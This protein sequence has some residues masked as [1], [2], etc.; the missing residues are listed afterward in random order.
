MNLTVLEELRKRYYYVSHNFG[1]P[2]D[3]TELMDFVDDPLTTNERVHRLLSHPGSIAVISPW[4]L[5]LNLVDPLKNDLVFSEPIT[6]YSSEGRFLYRVKKH[7]GI[8]GN[9]TLDKTLTLQS[10]SG[11]IYYL[12]YKTLSSYRTLL[13]VV[14]NLALEPSLPTNDRSYLEAPEPAMTEP[15]DYHLILN[16]TSVVGPTN[17]SINLHFLPGEPTL[18]PT[19]EEVIESPSST[20]EPFI[21]NTSDAIAMWFP[22]KSGWLSFTKGTTSLIPL[23]LSSIEGAGD[24]RLIAASPNVYYIA[25]GAEEDTNVIRQELGLVSRRP[26]GFTLSD[27]IK[28]KADLIYG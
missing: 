27:K 20:V 5:Y 21:L 1:S 16:S 3:M 2:E 10:F 18:N 9:S 26:P 7:D 17:T 11:A 13:L 4:K 23:L 6:I 24:D 28:L 12:Q 25:L 8:F 15:S 14:N 22:Q 19:A